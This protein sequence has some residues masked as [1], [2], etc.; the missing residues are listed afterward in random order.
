MMAV[1]TTKT[2]IQAKGKCGRKLA[3]LQ[4]GLVR[5]VTS[6]RARTLSSTRAL[7]CRC[8]PHLKQAFDF[9]TSK[10][11]VLFMRNPNAWTVPSF[12]TL[13]LLLS[14]W[15]GSLIPAFAW[16]YRWR[17]RRAVMLLA[18]GPPG[19]SLIWPLKGCAAAQGMVFVLSILNRI[20]NITQVC[21]KQGTQ[22]RASLS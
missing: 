22:L 15:S 6:D 20:Y 10:W 11:P 14:L 13:K 5:T 17:S 18:G 1:W 4:D 8:R 3:I 16:I 9:V 7:W 2:N 12:I 21:P 19:H